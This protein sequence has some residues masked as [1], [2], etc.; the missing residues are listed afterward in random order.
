M[1]DTSRPDGEISLG[2][3][4]RL[5]EAEAARRVRGKSRN[6][7][8]AAFADDYVLLGD[9]ATTQTVVS[10]LL[11]HPAQV[12]CELIQGNRQRLTLMLISIAMVCML[13]YGLVMGMF[14][15]GHQLWAV[16][17]K[18]CLGLLLSAVICLP[19]LYI[20]TCLAGGDQSLSQ[21]ASLLMATLALG[22]ILLIGFAPVAW[23]FSQA[24]NATAF[25]GGIHLAF[26]GIGVLFG[27]R[28]LESALSHLS[29]C[30]PGVFRTWATIFILVVL[31]MTTTLRP[32][33]GEYQ[34]ARLLGKK[35]FLQHWSAPHKEAHSQVPYLKHR[36]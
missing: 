5:H 29:R 20:F 30:N 19:S 10:A 16:P 13:G 6:C 8:S 26:W 12:V 35:F 36:R 3:R 15:G 23:V 21:V 27:L 25:M 14:S 31:Q 28:L 33:V 9:N 32:L 4:E 22:G 18:V 24:T 34:G 2:Q 1:N 7:A 11:K 17:A